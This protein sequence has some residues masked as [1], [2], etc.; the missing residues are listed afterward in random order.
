MTFSQSVKNQIIRAFS[1]DACCSLSFL[2]AY[3]HTAGWLSLS[4]GNMRLTLPAGS[5]AVRQ[6][7]VRLLHSRYGLSK[8]G[9]ADSRGSRSLKLEG[10]Q[11]KALLSDGGILTRGEDG[12]FALAPG[13]DPYLTENEC[14]KRSYIAGAFCGSGYAGLSERGEGNSV[15]VEFAVKSAQLAED[16][17]KLLAEFSVPSKLSA[18]G[19]NHLVYIKD[20][21]AAADFFALLGATRAL[22][23]LSEV[24]VEREASN[25]ENRKNNCYIANVDKT[26]DAAI[27]QVEAITKLDADGRLQSL[28]PRLREAAELRLAHKTDSIDELAERAGISKSGMNNR[29][30]R[31]AAIAAQ[32]GYRQLT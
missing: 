31:L 20:S 32:A 7:L 24:V 4:D 23:K 12:C 16:I 17:S 27:K 15:H 30:R 28:P 8:Q 29:L 11:A 18:R 22:L 25:L 14:C 2:S 13:L 6:M 10:A 1:G 3:T 9:G 5:G 21:R 19:E 26:V